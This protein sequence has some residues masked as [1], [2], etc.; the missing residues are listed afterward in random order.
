MEEVIQPRK[1]PASAGFLFLRPIDVRRLYTSRLADQ[2]IHCILNKVHPAGSKFRMFQ[3]RRYKSRL[4]NSDDFGRTFDI[5]ANVHFDESKAN[6]DPSLDTSATTHSTTICD[7]LK[8][9]QARALNCGT[10]HVWKLFPF[11]VGSALIPP[12]STQSRCSHH[13][14]PPCVILGRNC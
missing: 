9:I 14:S 2:R 5:S 11:A 4:N 10:V 7:A 6:C 13:K 8:K 12:Q 1:K 3:L